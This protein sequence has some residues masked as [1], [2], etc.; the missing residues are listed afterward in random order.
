MFYL[1]QKFVANLGNLYLSGNIRLYGVMLIA[2]YLKTVSGCTEKNILLFA[3]LD[4]VTILSC[5]ELF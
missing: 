4:I 3:F 2:V 1:N 5:K